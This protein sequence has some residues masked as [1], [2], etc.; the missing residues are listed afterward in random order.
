MCYDENKK[1][2]SCGVA[3][4]NRTLCKDGLGTELAK[5]LRY[6]MPFTQTGNG[7]VKVK[8]DEAEVK[9]E[10]MKMTCFLKE[11]TE[12]GIHYTLH[13]DYYFPDLNLPEAPRQGI[14]HY[15]RMRKAYLE[16]YRPG[17]YERLILSGKLNDHLA[18]TE[19]ACTK[20]MESLIPRMTQAEGVDEKLKATDQ[21]A[22]VGR[23][24]SIRQRAEESVLR[25]LV[26]D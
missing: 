3:Y 13:G 4:P 10:D 24:N 12:N 6:F 15:G 18:A 17:L 11:I 9:K 8:T 20:R 2:I 26:F 16:E 21:M 19:V 25:E 22:W 23:M 1:S 7:L 14:G 5:I